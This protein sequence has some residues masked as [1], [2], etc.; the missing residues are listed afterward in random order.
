MKKQTI[1]NKI[2]KRILEVTE[3]M[4]GYKFNGIIKGEMR[5]VLQTLKQ[6][7]LDLEKLE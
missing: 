2:N 5:F 6:T 7:K 3:R 4:R 1:V